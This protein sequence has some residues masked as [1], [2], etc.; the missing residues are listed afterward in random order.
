[1]ERRRLLPLAVMLFII[2]AVALSR[3]SHGVRSVDAVGLS[4]GGFAMGVGFA[5]L[6]FGRAGRLKG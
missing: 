4:G 5:L 1:M 3:Y 6:V 2:G